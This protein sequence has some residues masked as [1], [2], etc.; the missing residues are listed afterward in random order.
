MFEATFL[1]RV[2]ITILASHFSDYFKV[3]NAVNIYSLYIWFVLVFFKRMYGFKKGKLF[4]FFT[5][6]YPIEL[7]KEKKICKLYESTD[8]IGI[9]L[10][11]KFCKIA[12][13]KS[14]FCF[15]FPVKPS[16]KAK[17]YWHCFCT[18]PFT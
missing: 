5:A 15:G 6:F 1:Y 7:K 13:T 12:L 4:F 10:M 18:K 11:G 3:K 16:R 17:N 8:K 14:D 9:S 2:A